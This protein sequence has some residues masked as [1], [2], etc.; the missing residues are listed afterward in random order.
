MFNF[1]LLQLWILC[2]GLATY[3][4]KTLSLPEHPLSCKRKVRAGSGSTE[5]RA[6]EKLPAL[7]FQ[8]NNIIVLFIGF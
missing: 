7:L 2:H 1:Y 5:L 3:P 6:Q 4:V 8:V